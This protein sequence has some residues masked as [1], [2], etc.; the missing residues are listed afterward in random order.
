M[1]LEH[2]PVRQEDDSTAV[3]VIVVPVQKYLAPRLVD[4]DARSWS[5]WN[6]GPMWVCVSTCKAPSSIRND[7]GRRNIRQ[8]ICV[9]KRC[10]AMRAVCGVPIGQRR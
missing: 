6:F 7:V 1:F 8:T 9:A 10:L 4:I 3:V 5:P 2:W